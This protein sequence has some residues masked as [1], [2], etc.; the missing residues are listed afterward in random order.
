MGRPRIANPKTK[1]LTTRTTEDLY[2]RLMRVFEKKGLKGDDW[3]ILF[4]GTFENDTDNIKSQVSIEKMKLKSINKQIRDLENQKISCE[5]ILEELNT[6]HGGTNEV[7]R[8]V[9]NILQRF[10]NQSVYNIIDFLDENKQLLETQAYLAGV[11]EDELYMMVFN[12]S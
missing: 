12:K 7:D 4:L 5:N 6:K 11:E 10:H 1:T 2:V 3:I 9:N 8:A